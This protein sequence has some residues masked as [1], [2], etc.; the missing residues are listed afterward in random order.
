M[1][2]TVFLA[3]GNVES[4]T[5]NAE[6]TEELQPVTYV[7][8]Q[9]YEAFFDAME[10]YDAKKE[11]RDDIVDMVEEMMEMRKESMKTEN[12]KKRSNKR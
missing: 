12:D 9:K 4:Y 2:S 8:E 3:D 1:A 6:L 7:N 10:G 5:K 11:F